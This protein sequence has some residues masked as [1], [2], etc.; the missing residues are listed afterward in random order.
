VREKLVS[1]V[2]GGEEALARR[3]LERIDASQRA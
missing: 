2:Q 3:V 1:C